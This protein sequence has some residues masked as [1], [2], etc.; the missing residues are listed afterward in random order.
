MFLLRQTVKGKHI[1]L[2]NDDTGVEKYSSTLT[3]ASFHL[4]NGST[5]LTIASILQDDEPGG[6]LQGPDIVQLG[7]RL[8][9][10]FDVRD[11]LGTGGIRG[12]QRLEVPRS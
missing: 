9:D 3:T 6:S 12:V 10:R 4:S 7:K 8:G 1:L 5:Q 2:V 11:T